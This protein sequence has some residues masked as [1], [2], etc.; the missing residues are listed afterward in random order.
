VS[1]F[2]KKTVEET[3]IEAATSGPQDDD[4]VVPPGLDVSFDRLDGAAGASP[5]G[6]LT[7]GPFDVADAPD[8]RPRLDFGSLRVPAVDGME[9]RVETADDGRLTGIGLA[10]SGTV[11]QV[12]PF[13]APR[14]SGIWDDVRTDLRA[15]LTSQGGTVEESTG[16]FGPELRARLPVKRPDGTTSHE[17]A[18]FLGVDGPRWFLRGVITGAGAVDPERARLV[19]EMFAGVVVVRGDQAAPPREPLPLTLPEGPATA[20][21]PGEGPTP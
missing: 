13:A 3:G 2:R 4:V 17:V 8:D 21:A 20:A 12:Q 10:V 14:T 7:T 11:L 1:L 5:G 9:V 19:E 18:R 16:P 15:G 6:S